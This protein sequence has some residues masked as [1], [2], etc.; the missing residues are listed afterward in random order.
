MLYVINFESM[1]ENKKDELIKT[2]IDILDN[3]TFNPIV[4]KTME[5]IEYIIKKGK[6]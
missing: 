3:T 5:V 2:T 4:I 6:H 1:D